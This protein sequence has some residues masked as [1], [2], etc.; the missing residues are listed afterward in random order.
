MQR[1]SDNLDPETPW[2]TNAR[3]TCS[4]AKQKCPI[5]CPDCCCGYYPSITTNCDEASEDTTTEI[6]DLDRELLVRFPGWHVST[7]CEWES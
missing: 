6:D 2:S 5:D 3:Q 4:K 7:A 1:S